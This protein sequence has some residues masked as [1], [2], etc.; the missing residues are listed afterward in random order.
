MTVRVEVCRA[1]VDD[2]P[3][4]AQLHVA[5]FPGFFLTTLGDGFLTE[6]YAGAIALPDSVAFV[7]R[8]AEGEIVGAVVGVLHERGFHRRAVSRRAVRSVVTLAIALVRR[9]T[10]LGPLLTR[11]PTVRRGARPVSGSEDGGLLASLFVDAAARGHGVGEALVGAWVNRAR[12]LGASSAYLTTD[13]DGN[14]AVN[15]FYDRLGWG[16]V[17]QED[18]GSGRPRNRYRFVLT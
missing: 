10:A 1:R 3:A 8:G 14:E 18:A 7:A 15:R 5:S 12:A 6:F 13:A 9:P 17:G 2:A 11:L 4:V 16:L